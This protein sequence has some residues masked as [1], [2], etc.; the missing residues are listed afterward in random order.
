[1]NIDPAL[2][3]LAAAL[4]GEGPAVQLTPGTVPG[5]SPAVGLIRPAELAAGYPE[6][7]G[8]DI[9]AVVATSGST[10]TPKRTMLS[11]DALSASSMGTA[12][13]LGG[14]GQ[15]LL[16]LPVNFVAGLQVLVRSLFAGTR[17]WVMD[18]S[19][20][21]TAAAFTAAAGELT[22]R[23]RF[24]SLVPTQLE[25]LL[26]DPAPQTLAVLRRFNAIL[27][28]G[29]RARPSLLDAARAAGLTVVTTYGSSETCGGCVYNG[30]PLEGVRAETA[31]GRI[32][33]GG[34]VIASG[35][36][37]APTLSRSVFSTEAG[38]RWYRTDDLGRFGPAGELEVLGRVDDVIITGG[39]KVSAQLV[40]G[41]LEGLDGVSHAFAAGLP[42]DEWGQ[43]VAAVVVSPRP[44][45]ELLKEA[46]DVLE[47]AAVP[48]L[49]VPV[50]RIPLLPNGKPD[51]AAIAALLAAAR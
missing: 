49:L 23:T 16:A 33:L 35:Y 13:A 24:T 47:P 42:D 2:K 51:R 39:V 9:A 1:M 31:E 5:S 50:Q 26:T 25:R 46:A 7:L 48:K 12:L 11:I 45:G 28:G 6:G 20:G 4:A 44:V 18:S 22:D 41:R 27:L 21:F 29:A 37:S 3:A 17:P 14:E 15:W 36:L 38:V 30:V 40:A 32:R 34:D 8:G 19:G 43:L 10:G